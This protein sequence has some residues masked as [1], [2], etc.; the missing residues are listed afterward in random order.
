MIT[1]KSDVLLEKGISKEQFLVNRPVQS[2]SETKLII[3]K[4]GDRDQDW[5]TKCGVCTLVLI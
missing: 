5:M 3:L 2:F 4:L 1:I